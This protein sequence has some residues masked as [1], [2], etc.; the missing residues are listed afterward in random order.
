MHVHD[1]VTD[2][3]L[4]PERM[5]IHPSGPTRPDLTLFRFT[6]RV[7]FDTEVVGDLTLL[8]D[9]RWSSTGPSGADANVGVT[10]VMELRDGDVPGTVPGHG[11]AAPAPSDGPRA[12][13]PSSALGP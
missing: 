1:S 8:H 4:T 10:G 3:W 6:L 13:G 2:A 9:A 11:H 7:Q 5:T 12:H